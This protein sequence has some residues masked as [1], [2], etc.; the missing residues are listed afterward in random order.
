MENYFFLILVAVVGIIRWIA[1]AAENKRN[2]EAQKRGGAPSAPS[3]TPAPSGS[4][5]SSEEER[6]R[7]FFEALGLPTADSPPPKVQPRP[8]AP[9]TTAD[10]KFQPVDPS[11]VP[12]ARVNQPPPV[13]VA[14]PP[15]PAVIKPA[16]R[17]APLPTPETS[18]FRVPSGLPAMANEFEVQQIGAGDADKAALA[19]ANYASR[20]GTQQGLR[21]AIVL[22]EIF[23]PPRSMQPLTTVG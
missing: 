14:P 20:L 22:R 6:V 1:Q 15:L 17:T 13:V 2:A 19:V 18:V 12:R 10:R 8:S 3:T 11:P 9:Q 16:I 5:P 23:G 4:A 21:E 7:K